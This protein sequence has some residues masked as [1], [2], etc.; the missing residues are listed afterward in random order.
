M[1]LYPAIDLRD[2]RCVRL[3]EGDFDQETV[4]GDDPLLVARGFLAA[5]ARWIHVVDLDAARRQGDNRLVI[6]ALAAALPIPIEVGGG[7]RDGS[8]LEV[9]VARVVVGS[10]AVS[11]PAAVR[12]LAAAYPGRVAAGVDHRGGSVRVRGWEEGAGVSVDEVLAPLEGSPLAGVIVTE[13]GR[14]GTLAGPDVLGLASVLTL[15]ALPVIASG[16]VSTLS[17]LRALAR[18]EGGAGAGGGGRRL[19]GVIVGKALYERRFGVAEA[20]GALDEAA[21]GWTGSAA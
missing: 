7:V 9:G 16:G 19:A 20:L 21:A 6:A 2:G 12:A 17:D 8:L 13:I 11:D 4:Y 3:V 10:L 1:E 15:T 14:D 18:L 5:G